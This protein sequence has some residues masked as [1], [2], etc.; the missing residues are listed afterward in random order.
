ML[1]ST[2]LRLRDMLTASAPYITAFSVLGAGCAASVI[3]EKLRLERAVRSGRERQEAL[4]AERE[5]LLGR[6][7]EQSRSQ[8]RREAE[9]RDSRARELEGK[10]DRE[11]LMA[12]FEEK[13]KAERDKEEQLK[14]TLVNEMEK[15][16]ADEGE[17]WKREFDDLISQKLSLEE[18]LRLEKEEM[19]LERAGYLAELEMVKEEKQRQEAEVRSRSAA[20]EQSRAEQERMQT[21]LQARL[22]ES[23]ARKETLEKQIRQA[24]AVKTAT[25]AQSEARAARIAALER[26]RRTEEEEAGSAQRLLTTLADTLE[27][28]YQCPT[29]LELFICPVS[30][31]CGH[32]YCWLCLAQWKN[33][34]G[35]TRGDLGTCPQCREP[36]VHE[37]RVYAIDH[38][39]EA[40]L[41]QLGEEKQRERND[42]LQE[43]KREEEE[44]KAVA[45][46]AARNTA[47]RGRAGPGRWSP[48]VGI[49]RGSPGSS[50][51]RGRGRR[52][53]AVRQPA[54]LVPNPGTTIQISTSESESDSEEEVGHLAALLYY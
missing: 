43:R 29:C 41:K 44:F 2:M 37:N 54:R 28:E 17:K 25:A 3:K 27:T 52:G 8:Q 32:T 15:K 46:V 13:L 31:N 30:L 50:T 47:G 45:T 24:E 26:E 20:L 6:L 9:L 51:G 48:G 7:E 19:E 14:E 40:M 18:K 10:A 38:M 5:Q 23:E 12:Q 42:K 21:E 1:P 35:R 36:V 4:Q 33:S 11:T 39:I 49:G 22:R 53:M 16:L 34:N